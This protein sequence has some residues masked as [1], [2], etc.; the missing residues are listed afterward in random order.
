MKVYRLLIESAKRLP[1]GHEYDFEETS[2]AES[3]FCIRL[4]PYTPVQPFAID[5]SGFRRL[6]PTIYEK[7]TYLIDIFPMYLPLH[8]GARAHS[9]DKLDAERRPV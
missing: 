6:R 9:Q 3:R 1:G 4:I 2:Y 7:I 5:A 8:E